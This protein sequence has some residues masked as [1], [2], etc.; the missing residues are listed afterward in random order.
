[1]RAWQSAVIFFLVFGAMSVFATAENNQ[2][3]SDKLTALSDRVNDLEEKVSHKLE[4]C[5]L[6]FK[7]YSVVLNNC[8]NRTFVHSVFQ[9]SGENS[10]P[11]QIGCGYYQLYCKK[12]H[13][14]REV[15]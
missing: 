5:E 2:D 9:L 11:V 10:G 12:T 15:N 7:K 8:P 14:D 13:P 3:L 4:Y 1:M 6:R